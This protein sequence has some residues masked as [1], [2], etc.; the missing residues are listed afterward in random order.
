MDVHQVQ[1]ILGDDWSS[2][3]M[4]GEVRQVHL[5][6][7]QDEG[8]QNEFENQERPPPAFHA[9]KVPQPAPSANTI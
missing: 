1:T 2:S 8:N 3:V 7:D 5:W 9:L 6:Q 4:E